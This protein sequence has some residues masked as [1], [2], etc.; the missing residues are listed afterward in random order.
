M[1][2]R[3]L[4]TP[5]ITLANANSI[6]MGQGRCFVVGND[7]IAVFRQRDGRIFAALNRC[8]HRQGPLA[9]GIVG[10]GRVICPLHAHQFNLA[11]GEGSENCE[12]IQTFPVEVV[13]GNLVMSYECEPC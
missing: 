5:M 3:T 12:R 9:D 13:N 6:P 11:T 10:D 8:P 2:E 1:A 7:E 4:T